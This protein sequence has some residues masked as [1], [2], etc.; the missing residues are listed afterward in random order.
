M[1]K[2]NHLLNI[3]IGVAIGSFI[4]L[5]GYDVWKLNVDP[6]FYHA[7][8]MP[9]SFFIIV[10]GIFS[11]IIILICIIIKMIIKNNGKNKK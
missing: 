5:I 9:F 10:R 7:Q 8:A 2:I 3:I 6:M 4:G 1:K 11:G